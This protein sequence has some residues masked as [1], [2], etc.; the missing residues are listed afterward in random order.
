MPA[1]SCS[2]QNQKRDNVLRYLTYRLLF[3]SFFLLGALQLLLPY[4]VRALYLGHIFKAWQ[5]VLCWKYIRPS[6]KK[7]GYYVGRY[8]L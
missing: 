4:R 6:M 3:E 5:R 1:A 2:P 7:G 8:R